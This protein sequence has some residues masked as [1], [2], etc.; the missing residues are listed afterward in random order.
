MEQEP[1][2]IAVKG[3]SI[4]ACSKVAVLKAPVSNGTADTVN[5]LPHAFF[6]LG[7][8][9]FTEE[10]LAGNDIDG[11]LTPHTGKFAITLFEK[12]GA[13]VP[14]DGGGSGRPLDGVEGVSGIFGAKCG[15]HSEPFGRN[16]G[17][18]SIGMGGR[19]SIQTGSGGI[20]NKRVML[21][22]K[23]GHTRKIP[24]LPSPFYLEK[25]TISS[26]ILPTVLRYVGIDN[27]ESIIPLREK[28]S[29]RRAKFIKNPVKTGGSDFTFLGFQGGNT[30]FVLA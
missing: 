22:G 2:Q 25:R 11:K 27:N 28:E 21:G 20:H 29:S 6:P 18:K 26:S 4:P 12:D 9:W 17:L 3:F 10:I 30:V 19:N 16:C 24:A 5:D 1:S 8:V 15:D 13:A 7:G 23:S 14:F